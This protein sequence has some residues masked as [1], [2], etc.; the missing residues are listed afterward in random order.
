MQSWLKI[1]LK[2][3]YT[4]FARAL[5]FAAS[6]LLVVA[7]L[8]RQGYFKYEIQKGKAWLHPGLYAPFDFPVF[9]KVELIQVEKDSI[10][11]AFVPY[12]SCDSLILPNQLDKFVKLYE[13]KWNEFNRIQTDTL[14]E[15]YID[16]SNSKDVILIKCISIIKDIYKQGVVESSD[17]IIGQVLD[18]TGVKIY[19]DLNVKNQF[20]LASVFTLKHAYQNIIKQIEMLSGN[21]PFYKAFLASFNYN[22]FIVAN[23]SYNFE[24]SEKVLNAR[25]DEISINQGMIQS[26][27]KIISK[28]EIIDDYTFRVLNSLKVEYE[29]I[30][31]KSLLWVIIGQM[32]MV[33]LAFTVLFMFLYSF[34]HDI[35]YNTLKTSFI[36]FLVLFCIVLAVVVMEFTTESIYLLPFTLLPIIVRTFYDTRLAQFTYL[37]TILI[38]GMIAPNSFE[39]IFISVIAGIVSILSLTNQYR[40]GRLFFTALLVFLSYSLAYIGIGLI[41]EG[42]WQT[43]EYRNIIFFGINGLLLLTSYPLI[44]IFEKVFGFLSDATLLELSDTNQ[45][46]LRKLADTAPGT[47]QHSLQV[48]NLAEEAARQIGGNTL[49]IRTGALYHDIGKM[50]SPEYFIENL[51][52]DHNPHDEL[53]FDQSAAIIIG[54]VTKGIELARDNGLP[55]M[56][57]DFI[58][59]HHGTTTVQYFYRSY[60]KKYPKAEADIRMFSYPGPRPFSKETSILMMADSVEAASRSLKIYSDQTISQLVDDIIDYQVNMDQFDDSSITFKDINTVKELFKLKLKNIYHRRISYNSEA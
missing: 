14:N 5:F 60:L 56:I 34:R 32:I 52:T 33:G 50:I 48:A 20:Q 58:R 27:N 54:H 19:A 1:K 53:E 45:P 36:L 40:R 41:Q 10:I 24:L 3:K 8:P 17:K 13:V 16:F 47:F 29:S 4:Y 11:N 46:L 22:D 57:I 51:N 23:L 12:Y 39:F 38:I 49:L 9:K 28:G 35:L 37:I 25:L 42:Q 43:I 59:T 21:N 6:V 31:Q 15:N 2:E 44:F 30:V 26:G 7:I 18:S 55:E